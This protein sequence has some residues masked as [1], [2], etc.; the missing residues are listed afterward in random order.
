MRWNALIE[1]MGDRRWERQNIWWTL[2][3]QTAT[4]CQSTI[5]PFT[6]Y[7]FIKLQYDDGDVDDDDGQRN[8][9]Y[10]QYLYFWIPIDYYYYYLLLI[11]P[12]PEANIATIDDAKPITSQNEKFDT[13]K[14]KKNKHES[15]GRLAYCVTKWKPENFV[16]DWNASIDLNVSSFN[17]L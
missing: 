10:L 16:D 13:K 5:T 1:T 4:R 15:M 2:Y 14:K 12:T 8:L 9:H 11:R 3:N 7:Y 6:A 17:F